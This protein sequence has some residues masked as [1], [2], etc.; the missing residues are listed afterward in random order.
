VGDVLTDQKRTVWSALPADITGAKA[1]RCGMEVSRAATVNTVIQ[2][3]AEVHRSLQITA[4][5]FP[6][7]PSTCWHSSS[8]PHS[9]GLLQHPT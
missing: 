2:M 3:G 1:D 7:M 9:I 4:V 5:G 8:L 6:N